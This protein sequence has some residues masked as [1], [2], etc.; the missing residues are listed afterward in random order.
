MLGGLQILGGYSLSSVVRTPRLMSYDRLRACD[1]TY[2]QRVSQI[3]R[4]DARAQHCGD[5]LVPP[6][7][8]FYFCF[9]NFLNFRS[10]ITCI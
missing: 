5:P 4:Q 7:I 6:C 9:G 3:V 1:T 2:S 8:L 10:I